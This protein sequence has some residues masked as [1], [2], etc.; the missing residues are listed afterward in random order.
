MVGSVARIAL[1]WWDC[2]AP[3]SSLVGMGSQWILPASTLSLLSTDQ[4][5]TVSML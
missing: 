5:A 4:V 1:T 3:I 2:S